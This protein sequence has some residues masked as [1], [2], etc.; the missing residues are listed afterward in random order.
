MASL[1]GRDYRACLEFLRVAGDVEGPDPFP[2]AALGELRR[3]VPCDCVSYGEYV[4][5]TLRRRNIHADPAPLLPAPAHVAEAYD[6]LRHE[7]PLLPHPETAGR[8]IRRSDVMSRRQV[9][10]S[11]LY[12]HVDRPLGIEYT[13]DLW[14]QDRGGV[15]GGFG[16]DASERDFTER[17]CLL[18]DTLASHLVQIVRR[19]AARK[20]GA[21]QAASTDVLTPR[22]REVLRLVATGLTNPEIAAALWIAPGTVRKHLDNAYAKLGV[23]SRAAAIAIAF[24]TR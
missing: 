24:R 19:A 1:A 17:D 4:D 5:G 12:Q 23:H 14:L 8:A 13:M 9:V 18:L 7:N 11:K 22:E 21:D 15:V 2:E 16:F 10:A 6:A 3:L 20:V